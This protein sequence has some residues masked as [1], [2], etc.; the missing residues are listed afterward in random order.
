M[1]QYVD[2]YDVYYLTLL[3]D[4]DGKVIAVNSSDSDG[5]P[6]KTE[7][8]YDRNFADERWFQDAA[9]RQVLRVEG[10]DVHWHRR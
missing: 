9:G 10:Q 5:K 1:N 7:S 3:V 4:T 6:I 8:L 2:L